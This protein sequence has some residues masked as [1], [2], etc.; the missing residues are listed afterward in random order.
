MQSGNTDNQGDNPVRASSLDQLQMQSGSPDNQGENSFWEFSP[1]QSQMQSGSPDNQGNNPIKASSLDQF[2]SQQYSDYR[3]PLTPRPFPYPPLHNKPRR[4]QSD[5]W[6]WY[7]TQTPNRKIVIGWGAIMAVLLFFSSIIVA[8]ASITGTFTPQSA[9]TPIGAGV[10]ESPTVPHQTPISIP[11]Q[12][13]RS[14]PT[15]APTQT[16]QSSQSPTTCSGVNC[17]PWGY[18]FSQGNY[19]TQPPSNFCAYFSCILNFWS[20]H[21]YVVECQDGKYSK[22]G[23]LQGPCKHHGGD[24]R[25]L[26]SH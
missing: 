3:P 16:R 23:G 15:H 25:P 1:G 5:L 18:D 6:K 8:S 17:N 10:F 22:L 24:P 7:Q 26:Y 13:S 14:T 12:E 19:V 4:R 9:A 11:T 20:G 2:Q 21:G